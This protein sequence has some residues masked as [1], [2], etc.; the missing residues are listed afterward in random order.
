V[1]ILSE[2]WFAF[3]L[4]CGLIL[5][6]DLILSLQKI[7]DS[8]SSELR[9][10]VKSLIT[11]IVIGIGV[12]VRPGWLLWTGF[13]ALLLII[14]DRQQRLLRFAGAGLIAAGCVLALSPWAYRNSTV[15][16]HWIFTSLWS[17]PSL[18]DGLHPK[19]TGASD[20]RFFDEENLSLTM[21]EFDVNETYKRRAWDFVAGNP[22]RAMEL[23]AI[24][25]LRYLSP[26][27]NAEGVSG[28]SVVFLSLVFYVPFVFLI[29]SGLPILLRRGGGALL[30]A[31]PFL[32]FL[33]VHMVFVGSVRYRLPVE[34]P[35]SVIAAAG[36]SKVWNVAPNHNRA[37]TFEGE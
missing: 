10:M 5:L 6:S 23:G 26:F 31:G 20:M 33:L 12:L 35:L 7:A 28:R 11:G 2:T 24:K 17:G 1:L 34:F 27:P 21:S 29:L 8:G 36:I 22:I 37:V 14:S 25:A 4:L 19:A 16:G 9:F 3:W 32:Q 18:Y 13:S 30:L 15:T